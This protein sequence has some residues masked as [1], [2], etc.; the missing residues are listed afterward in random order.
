MTPSIPENLCLI[1]II[2]STPPAREDE[3]DEEDEE[4]EDQNDEPAVIREPDE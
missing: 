2:G 3:G 1:T 4:D